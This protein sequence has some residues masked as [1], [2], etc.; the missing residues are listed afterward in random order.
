M[1]YFKFKFEKCLFSVKRIYCLTSKYTVVDKRRW[2]KNFN[3]LIETFGRSYMFQFIYPVSRKKGYICLAQS[4]NETNLRWAGGIS[5][6]S[7]SSRNSFSGWAI[8]M[9]EFHYIGL[10][11]PVHEWMNEKPGNQGQQKLT[12]SWIV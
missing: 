5:V 3:T 2:E 9:H 4:V 8:C 11:K 1:I 7:L 6:D 10:K 12:N